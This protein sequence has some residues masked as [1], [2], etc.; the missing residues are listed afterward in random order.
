[1]GFHCKH[2]TDFARYRQNSFRA[3]FKNENSNAFRLPVDS[4][5]ARYGVISCC[6]R[7]IRAVIKP[8]R[9]YRV[10]AVTRLIPH[11]V[12]VIAD[13][14]CASCTALAARRGSQ[15]CAAA[16]E[17]RPPIRSLNRRPLLSFVS[18]FVRVCVCGFCVCVCVCLS[19]VVHVE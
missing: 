3:I 11:A 7:R 2:A 4:V 1:M 6:R 5:I 8:G 19:F 13:R 14:A 12:T 10:Y 15:H 16:G 18:L 9:V 17:N